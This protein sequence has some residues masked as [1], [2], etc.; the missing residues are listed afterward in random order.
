MNTVCLPASLW[1]GAKGACATLIQRVAERSA[2]DPIA[3]V[4]D[5]EAIS[6]QVSN[7]ELEKGFTYIMFR[8]WVKLGAIDEDVIDI[9]RIRTACREIPEDSIVILDASGYKTEVIV[10]ALFQARIGMHTR[11]AWP[12]LFALVCDDSQ[13]FQLA[14]PVAGAFYLQPAIIAP[15][16]IQRM[17][18]R[19]AQDGKSLRIFG[20]GIGSIT[21]LARRWSRRRADKADRKANRAVGW[22]WEE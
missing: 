8:E 11:Y 20:Q 3:L 5:R 19:L 13:V 10:R 1:H 22:V 7:P 17:V 15:A 9:E 16:T 4:I 6:R 2:T 12:R 14:Q 18:N 21:V